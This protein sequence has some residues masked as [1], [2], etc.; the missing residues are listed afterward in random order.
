MSL[1]RARMRS[2]PPLLLRQLVL[3]LAMVRM[4]RFPLL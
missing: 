4:H 2:L 1:C 3:V